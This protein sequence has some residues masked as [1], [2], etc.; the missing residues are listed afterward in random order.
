MGSTTYAVT[1]PTGLALLSG[2]PGDFAI[3]ISSG[4]LYAWQ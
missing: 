2:R 1:G 3:D 4:L